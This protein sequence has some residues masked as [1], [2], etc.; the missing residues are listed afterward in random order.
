M[1]RI[2][3]DGWPLFVRSA[4]VARYTSRIATALACDP[5][6]PEIVVFAPPGL[7]QSTRLEESSGNL[8]IR[9]S[10]AYPFVMGQPWPWLPRVGSTAS[11]LGNCDVF[12]ATSYVAPR[13]CR[14]PLVTNVHDLALLRHPELGTPVLRA[15]I[16]R[17]VA[18]LPRAAAIIT[19]SEATKAD[20]IE[21]CG[22]SP[23]EIHVVQNGCDPEFAPIG[24]ELSRERVSRSLGI[25]ERMIL[26][27]GTIEPRKNLAT[28]MRAFATLRKADRIPHKLVL[29]GPKGWVRTP[30]STLA[31]QLEIAGDVVVTGRVSDPMLADLYRSAEVFIC[32]SLY[33][34]FGFP[35]L[36]AMASGT[37]V[38]CANAGALPEVVGTAGLLVD[39][40]S[41][42]ELATAIAR[43]LE[44]AESARRMSSDGIERARGFTWQRAAAETARVYEKVAAAAR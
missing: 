34:G 27:V 25:S 14:A 4:G 22:V 24:R 30:L 37:P 29:A 40:R 15:M 36:E 12:H 39:P 1:M 16:E 11:A 5:S 8:S 17:C 38:V 28:L 7:R 10:W 3:L 26:H 33:E 32:P 23:D 42:S 44:D 43:V 13:G 18:A 2:A 31:S 19:A 6:R 41:E 35:A 20:L 9:R 21:L